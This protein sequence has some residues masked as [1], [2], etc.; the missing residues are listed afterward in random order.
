MQ[1]RGALLRER[2]SCERAQVC[3]RVPVRA[4]GRGLILHLGFYMTYIV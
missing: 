3:F 2:E 1:S 4:I